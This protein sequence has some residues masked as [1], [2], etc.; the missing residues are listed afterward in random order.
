MTGVVV[1]TGLPIGGTPMGITGY[2]NKRQP[3][4]TDMGCKV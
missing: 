1:E 3:T 4:A 2:A